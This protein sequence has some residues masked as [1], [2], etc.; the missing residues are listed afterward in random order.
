MFA[1]AFASKAMSSAVLGVVSIVAASGFLA[2]RR[3]LGV[4]TEVGSREV[5]KIVK[6]PGWNHCCSDGY[7]NVEVN[8]SHFVTDTRCGSRT[9]KILFL[10][11][12][13][14]SA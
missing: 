9:E 12:P 3:G 4:G 6:F 11:D 1:F 13:A 2:R 8:G 14:P 5:R 10:R 7:E